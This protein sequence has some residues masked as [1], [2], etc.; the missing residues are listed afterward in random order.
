[1]N[2]YYQP[3]LTPEEIA[4]GA[5]RPENV[6][7][8]YAVYHASKANN[9]YK[10]GKAFHIYRPKIIDADGVE[11]WGELNVDTQTGKLTVT[12]PQ[13]FLDKAKY[14]ILV[15]PTFGYTTLGASA[16]ANI[17]SNTNDESRRR[18]NTFTP[19]ESG[20]LDSITVGL[21][22]AN[23][24]GDVNIDVYAFMCE[25]DSGGSGSHG[26]TAG[27]ERADLTTTLTATWY[28]F[29][30]SSESFTAIPYVLG[31]VANGEE[32]LTSSD[33][34]DVMYD[35]VSSHNVYTESYTGAGSYA[36]A[37]AEDP[38]TETASSSSIHYSVYAT[39]TASGAAQNSNF[40]A[41]M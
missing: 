37:K 27:I 34:L 15:D 9:Q 8:S 29:T 40:L 31:A 19:S 39:Y 5:Q 13:D 25:E 32:L 2:F 4:E 12:I 7:G 33:R 35:T 21:K 14:P 18:G 3:E 41:F 26:E 30:A 16:G 24:P 1:L 11:I 22:L 38:W 20:T 36:T 23:T 28:T 17:A 6:V 10:A